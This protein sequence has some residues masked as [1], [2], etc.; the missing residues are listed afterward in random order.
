MANI[1]NIISQDMDVIPQGT[2]TV[3]LRTRPVTLPD[4]Q[5]KTQVLAA[6]AS[7]LAGLKIPKTIV[8]GGGSTSTTTVRYATMAQFGGF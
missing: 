4:F 3:I 6:I 8:S 5:T 7:A 2:G 1:Q